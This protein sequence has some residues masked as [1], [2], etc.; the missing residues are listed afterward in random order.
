MK[1]LLGIVVLGL[2]WCNISYSD[3]KTVYTYYYDGSCTPGPSK[4]YSGYHTQCIN[5]YEL[6]K[7]CRDTKDFTVGGARQIDML[8]WK[9]MSGG[10]IS[11]LRFRIAQNGFYNGKGCYAE[12]TRSG[13]LNG[14]STRQSMHGWVSSFVYS[15]SSGG[16]LAT[17]IGSLR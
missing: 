11:N 17:N 12:F 4:I 8:P 15:A 6:D 7:Y 3:S 10:T 2:F 5:E 16:Y 14:T 13:I 1:K 9:R